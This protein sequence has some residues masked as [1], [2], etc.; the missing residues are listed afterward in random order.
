M[1]SVRLVLCAGLLPVAALLGC[2]GSRDY[3][4]LERQRI[5]YANH[6]TIFPI[7]SGAVHNRPDC[8]ACHGGTSTFLEFTCVTCHE[9]AQAHTDSLHQGVDDYAWGATTCYDCHPDGTIAGVDHEPIFPIGAGAAHAGRRCS[10]CHT[11]PGDRRAFSCVTCHDHSAGLMDPAHA[12]VAGYQ[13]DSA[14]CLSCHPRAEVM[15]PVRHQPFFPI[16]SGRHALA[17]GECHTTAGDFRRFEC[18]LCHTHT[19][20]ET[21][22][23]HREVGDYSCVSSECYRCHPTGRGE[24]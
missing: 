13:F 5:D 4:S 20:A 23:R 6:G 8:D 19:C 2:W 22:P 17:C 24:D 14:A 21:D 15:T 1:K 16:A 9:H 18:I 11:V 7:D 12:G 3:P 10:E